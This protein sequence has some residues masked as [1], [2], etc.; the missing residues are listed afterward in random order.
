MF[1][2]ELS[3]G[4][5]AIYGTVAEFVEAIRRGEVGWHARVYHRAKD[6]WVSVTMH[7]LFQKVAGERP[8][9]KEWTFLPG[10]THDEPPVEAEA[11]TETPAAN[12]ADAK[13]G[14]A[15]SW[16]RVLGGLLGSRGG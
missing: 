16:R 4:K 11:P 13:K 3:P 2:V 1:L 9:R 10:Q 6:T 7:P 8:T 12:S 15:R 5:E 14:G